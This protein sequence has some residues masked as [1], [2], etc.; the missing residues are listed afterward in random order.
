[1]DGVCGPRGVSVAPSRVHTR[2][3]LG[4]LAILWVFILAGAV[5]LVGAMV[6]DRRSAREDFAVY[7][8]L[9][10][11]TSDGRNPYALDLGTLARERGADVHDI[12]RGSEP[13]TFLLLFEPLALLPLNVAYWIWQ[14]INLACLIG[15]LIVLLGGSSRADPALAATL[16]GLAMLYPPVGLHFWMG[17]SKL[18]L[19]LLLALAMRWMERAR[20]A[21]AGLALALAALLRIFPAVLIGYAIFQRR[22]RVANY[23]IVGL[24]AGAA[25]TTVGVG[26]AGAHGFVWSLRFL[27]GH[28]WEHDIAPRAFVARTLWAL[29]PHPSL[30]P[31]IAR[32]AI[33]GAADLA[34]IALTLRATLRHGKRSDPDWRVFSL[35]IATSVFL[36]PVAW[37]YDL[38]LMLIPFVQL[39]CAS[40]RGEAS[41]RAV[42]AAVASYLLILFWECVI[43]HVLPSG[44]ALQM[45]VG[46]AGF[47][48]LGAAWLAAYWFA[49]DGHAAAALPMRGGPPQPSGRLT[50]Q[51]S[52][53]AALDQRRARGL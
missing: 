2:L 9:A 27:T 15:A 4:G 34:A 24:F 51:A 29:Y 30:A 6:R 42:A 11:A 44:T 28:W 47:L 37:D 50:P 22:R 12:R 33:V 17:Q 16:A 43:G 18:P 46:E 8:F 23:A 41:R 49:V 5:S 39:A 3:E 38:V 21:A 13:P 1:M 53:S 14:G 35:W 36:L 45:T 7:Y 31:K 48:S 20:D 26:I 25:V 10:Q 32:Y 40:A 19:L 52:S